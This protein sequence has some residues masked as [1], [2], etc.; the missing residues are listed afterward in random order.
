[1]LIGFNVITVT[2]NLWPLAPLYFLLYV[3]L[4]IWSYIVLYK[5][6]CV[7]SRH[8]KSLFLKFIMYCPDILSLLTHLCTLFSL[9]FWTWTPLMDTLYLQLS[10]V[11]YRIICMKKDHLART[12][13][14]VCFLL[15][16]FLWVFL[17]LVK[18][19]STVCSHVTIGTLK[20][21]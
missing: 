3:S 10:L 21:V 7:F 13:R 16:F 1:M 9:N 19:T 2:N 11:K 14:R 8:F 17:C 4:T 18:V 12:V 15:Y 6:H 5:V 20:K